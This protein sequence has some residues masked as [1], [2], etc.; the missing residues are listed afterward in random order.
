LVLLDFLRKVFATEV[1]QRDI[2]IFGC[3]AEELVANPSPSAPEGGL[4]AM[5]LPCG[6]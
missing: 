5:V 1:I 6:E 2:D 4:Q 3:P